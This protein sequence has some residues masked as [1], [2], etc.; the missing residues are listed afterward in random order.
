MN[1][2]SVLQPQRL[3]EAAIG[4]V[5]QSVADNTTGWKATHWCLH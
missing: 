1:W 5:D 3:L 4:I 2:W